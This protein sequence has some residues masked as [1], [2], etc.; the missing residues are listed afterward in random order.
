MQKKKFNLSGPLAIGIA[1]LV[2]LIFIPINIIVS[3][4]DK[5]YDMTPSGK[6]TITPTMEKLLDETSDK[7]IDIYFLSPLEDLKEIA[8]GLPLYHLLTQLDERD[9][10]TLTCFDPDKEKDLAESL[11]PSGILGTDV[12]DV[13]VKCG[14]T[15]KKVSLKKIFQLDQNDEFSYSGEEFIA[16]AIKVVAGGSLPT[17]YF[18]E[19]YSDKTLE[20]NYYAFADEIKADNYDVKSLD[21]SQAGEV[22]EDAA[23]VYLAG[24]NK[25]ISDA[26]RDKLIRYIDNGGALSVLIGPSDTEGRFKNLEYIL[27]K[28]ELGIN[29]DIITESNPSITLPNRDDT[30]DPTWFRVSYPN[31]SDDTTVDLTSEI[32]TSIQDGTYPLAAISNVRSVTALDSQSGLIEKASIIENLPSSQDSYEYT[33]VSTPMGGDDE[34]AEVCEGLSGAPIEMGYYSYN[35]QTGAK[36]ILMGTDD[37]IDVNGYDFVLFD[38]RM[39]AL[40]TNTWMYNSDIDMGIGTKYNSYDNM[41]FESGEEATGVITLFTVIPAVLLVAGLGVWLKRRYA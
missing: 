19:G 3:Y 9:N 20:N 28:F 38:T 5:V 18:I 6:Y 27:A 21:L 16:G 13:F 37:M 32:N 26:D 14:D 25:D 15:A 30:Q 10:I 23:I 33:V 1:L 35:K 24:I 36:M 12:G 22:P 17:V 39:L 34:T 41:K 2:L 7:Q 11:D 40:Y 8:S 4:Y 29:Y 31:P